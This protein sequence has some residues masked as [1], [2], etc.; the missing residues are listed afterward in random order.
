MNVI[1]TFDKMLFENEIKGLDN[2]ITGILLPE[3][4]I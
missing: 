3:A 1:S 2:S 4:S